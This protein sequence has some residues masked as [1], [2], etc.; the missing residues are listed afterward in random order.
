MRRTVLAAVLM[1]LSLPLAGCGA[2]GEPAPSA[3][4]GPSAPATAGPSQAAS[5]GPSAVPTGKTFAWPDGLE[6]TATVLGRLRPADHTD[7]Q[8]GTVDERRLAGAREK[9]LGQ[10]GEPLGLRVQLTNNGDTP[11]DLDAVEVQWVGVEVGGMAR[12]AAADGGFEGELAPGGSATELSAW[13]VPDI[14]AVGY[15]VLVWPEGARNGA[16]GQFSG[17]VPGAS[18]RPPQGDDHGH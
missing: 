9:L 14:V 10:S 8:G 17:A 13:A 7:V 4:P 6:A 15:Q 16:A 18:L 5:A 1:S 2:G 11:L 3:T 12:R